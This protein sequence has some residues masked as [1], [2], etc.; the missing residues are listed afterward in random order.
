MSHLKT[1]QSALISV[2]YK[3]GLAELVQELHKNKVLIYSTG[4]TQ[5]FIESLKIPV[6]LLNRLQ[7]FL[8][9]LAEE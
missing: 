1:I 2:Y 7:I 9:Y 5:S 6:I 8:K 3:E 4:G